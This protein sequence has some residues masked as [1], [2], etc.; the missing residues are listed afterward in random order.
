VIDKELVGSLPRSGV[1][2]ESE[3]HYR[4]LFAGHD[5]VSDIGEKVHAYVPTWHNFVASLSRAV[6]EKHPA[7]AHDSSVD[8]FIAH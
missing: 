3:R 6:G 4:A 1:V 2:E 5:H 7:F 8:R